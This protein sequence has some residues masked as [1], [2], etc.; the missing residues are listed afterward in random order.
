MK[1]LLFILGVFALASCGN[2]GVDEADIIGDWTL[3]SYTEGEENPFLKNLGPLEITDCDRKTVWHFLA[4]DAETLA[5]GTEVKVLRA[6]GAEGCKFYD[7]ES[8]WAVK[9]GK[10]FI[11]TTSIGGIGGR[12]YAGLF[13]IEEFGDGKMV[14]EISDATMTFMKED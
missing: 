6:E 4:D 10:L 3:S 14:L 11:S 13:D 8:S 12:S 9:S 5:D 1:K 2:R 7:F